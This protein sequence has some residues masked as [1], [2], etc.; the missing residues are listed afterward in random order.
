MEDDQDTKFLENATS[1]E[2]AAYNLGYSSGF[3]EGRRRF[4]DENVF[5]V[6]TTINLKNLAIFL[7]CIAAGALSFAGLAYYFGI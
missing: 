6:K 5:H 3:V 4:R 1:A 7:G 2:K